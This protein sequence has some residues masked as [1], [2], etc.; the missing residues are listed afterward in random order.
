MP[1]PGQVSPS[2]PSP[3]GGEDRAAALMI[4]IGG[5]ALAL[6][7]A[8]EICLMP[9]HRVVVLWHVDAEFG[10]TV[11]A[12]GARYV[13]GRPDSQQG[14]EAAGVADAIA[15]LALSTD[16][17]LNLQ[18]ALRARYANPQIRIVLRPF[19]RAFATKI[20]QNLANCSVLS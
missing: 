15:I 2:D 20:E 9:G 17:E 10:A 8:R 3:D 4:I 7:A 5:D 19:H 14:L 18:S 11:A 13:A 12:A 1:P 6:S 16:E